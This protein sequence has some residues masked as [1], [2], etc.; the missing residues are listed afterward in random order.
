MVECITCGGVYEPIQD[1]YEYYH[2]CPALT[3]REIADGLQAGTVQLGR[4]DRRRFDEARELDRLSP[5]AEGEVPR[6]RR[7]LESLNIERPNRRDENVTSEM[8]PTTKRRRIKAEGGGIR[9]ARVD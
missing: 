8:D 5:V 2:V 6:A 9:P 1:G 3:A 4:A 7:V